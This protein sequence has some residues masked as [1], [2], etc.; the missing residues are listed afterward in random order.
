MVAI[1]GARIPLLEELIV[2]ASIAHKI[3]MPANPVKKDRPGDWYINTATINATNAIV[4]QGKY[5]PE[6]KGE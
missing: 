1:L 3:K 5:K 6:A 4:H 2:I